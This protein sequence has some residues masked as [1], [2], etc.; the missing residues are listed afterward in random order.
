MLRFV[1]LVGILCLICSMAIY[2]ANDAAYTQV[3]P[4]RA[5]LR[6]KAVELMDHVKQEMALNNLTYS[7]AMEYP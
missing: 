4:F 3:N 7:G 5:L 2:A 1:V 6:S